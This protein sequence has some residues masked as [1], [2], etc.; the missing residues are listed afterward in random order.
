MFEPMREWVERV[1]RH[2]LVAHALYANQRFQERLGPQFAGAITYFSVLS[3]VPVLMFVFAML[4]MTMTV[5]RPDL[6]YQLTRE[7]RGALGDS[8]MTEPLV[9][10]VTTSLVSWR[11]VTTWALLGAGWAGS[12]WA[13]H[14]KRAVRVMWSNEFEDATKRRN[15]FAELGVNLLV[16]LGLIT[17]IGIGLGLASVGGPFSEQIVRWLGWESVPGIGFLVQLGAVLMTFVAGWVMFAF[18]FV[19]LPNEPVSPR[20]W[21]IGTLVG[22]LGV[23]V[24]Q[25]VAGRVLGIFSGNV[26][27]QIFGNT[28]VVM[29][30]FNTLAMFIL[31]TAA[32][33]GTE[34]YWRGA[35]ADA[36]APAAPAEEVIVVDAVEP[37]PVGEPAPWGG[38]PRPSRHETVRQDVAARGMKVNLGIGYGLGAATGLGLGAVLIGVVRRAR[39]F[40]SRKSR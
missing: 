17:T 21:L 11:S 30:L 40:L 34:G 15:F 14:L 3:L 26:S 5:L 23:T 28:I 36:D 32:W 38:I 31:F 6:L 12:R 2:P 24:L 37:E 7:I 4:G 16:F 10:L 33:V 22:A 19:V 25:S 39:E 1:K 13:G 20:A 18:L 9:D 27:A 8:A 29:L 35:V